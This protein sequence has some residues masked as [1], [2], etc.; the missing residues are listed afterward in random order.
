MSKQLYKYIPFVL[1]LLSLVLK[2]VHITSYP[3]QLDEPFSIFTSNLDWAAFLGVF[4]EENNPPLHPILL[5]LLIEMLGMDFFWMRFMSVLFAS[6]AV[7]F[8]YKSAEKIGGIQMALVAAACMI[9]SNQQLMYSHQIRAYSLLVLLASMALY[10]FIRLINKESKYDLWCFGFVNALMMYTHFMGIICT[11]FLSVSILVYWKDKQDRIALFKSFL[12]SALL[13]VPYLPVFLTRFGTATNG[14]WVEAPQGIIS[15]YYSL[16]KF[17]NAPLTTIVAL[18]IL[19]SGIYVAFKTKE[20]IAVF[21][22]SQ[23]LLTF[24]GLLAFSYIMPLYL[25]RYLIFIA[26]FLYFFIAL[27]IQYWAV[28]IKHKIAKTLLYLLVPILMLATFEIDKDIKLSQ[29]ELWSAI[30]A[31]RR[32]KIVVLSPS[33]LDLN[34][35]YYADKEHYFLKSRADFDSVRKAD[36]IYLDYEFE[37]NFAT[38]NKKN[39]LLCIKDLNQKPGLKHIMETQ[40]SC[41]KEVYPGL[42]EYAPK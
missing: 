13:F 11:A 23:V 16:W 1:V 12:F 6:V 22:L 29:D 36:S 32:E 24:V 3:V 4:M 8:V 21:M 40:F 30:K 7:W 18:I 5:K 28:K 15:I 37:L 35:C 33:W 2:L 19:L 42:W 27:I 39:V 34:Y 17:L 14:T 9:F 20:R 10:Y 41:V 26:P 38:L 31:N 25:D